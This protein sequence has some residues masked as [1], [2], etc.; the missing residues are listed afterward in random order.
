MEEE[1][2]PEHAES[3]LEEISTLW[4]ALRDSR[5][6]GKERTP[7]LKL[8][9]VRY[10]RAIHNYVYSLVRNSHDADDVAQVVLQNLLSGSFARADP[11][12]GRFRDLLKAAVMNAVRLHYR[13]QNRRPKHSL[14]EERDGDTERASSPFGDEVWEDAA[15]RWSL[16][17]ETWERLRDYQQ[18]RGRW[19]H[20]VLLLRAQLP[21]A[22]MKTLAAQAEAITRHSFNEQS[23][24]QQLHRARVKFVHFLVRSVQERL[25][26]SEREKVEEYLVSLELLDYVRGVLGNDWSR[27]LT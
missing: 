25:E 17:D 7:A 19:Y 27:G 15:A 8:L 11:E 21:G 10:A 4:T 20:A 24:R 9:A 16:L 3:R 14:D 13:Q 26:T 18:H 5:R 1:R 23:F 12:R 6:T 22:D 2:G